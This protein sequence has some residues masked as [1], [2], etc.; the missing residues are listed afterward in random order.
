MFQVSECQIMWSNV[1]QIET[2]RFNEKT[3]SLVDLDEWGYSLFF[4]IPDTQPVINLAL[5][6]AL[7]G[8]PAETW[9]KHSNM[10]SSSVS[11]Y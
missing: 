9:T 1:K 7:L 6:G 2:F 4:F 5:S 10:F 8:E 11:L 3:I